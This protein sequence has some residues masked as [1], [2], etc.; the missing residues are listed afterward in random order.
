MADVTRARRLADRIR[1]IVAQYLET[2]VQDPRIG[3]LTVTDARVTPDLRD[4]TVFYTVLGDDKARA[5]TAAALADLTG[6]LRTE[7]GRQTGVKFTPTLTFMLDAVPENARTIED[8]LAAARS[9]DAEVA[10]LAH[11]ASFAGEADP[12]RHPDESDDEDEDP[13]S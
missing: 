12:Y 13:Q 4:A 3:F 7:V 2:R 5:D 6:T 9:R 10:A 8:L 11:G 1:V